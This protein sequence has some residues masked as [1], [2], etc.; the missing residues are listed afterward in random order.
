[1][2]NLSMKKFGT[3]IG[4]APG[5]ASDIVGLAS[6]GTPPALR[7]CV[8]VASSRPSVL[9]RGASAAVTPVVCFAAGGS[10]TSGAQRMTYRRRATDSARCSAGVGPCARR[11]R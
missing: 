5:S 9:P 7:S 3:P 2:R 11:A 6:V 8:R 10:L 4:A 1:M